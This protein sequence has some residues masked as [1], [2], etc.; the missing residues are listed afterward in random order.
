ML[1]LLFL[2]YLVQHQCSS[3]QSDNTDHHPLALFKKH[4]TGLLKVFTLMKL[5]SELKHSATDIKVIRT[6]QS[7]SNPARESPTRHTGS[8]TLQRKPEQKKTTALLYI[9]HQGKKKH[10]NLSWQTCKRLKQRETS[11]KINHCATNLLHFSP[12]RFPHS[13]RPLPSCV[14]TQ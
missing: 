11:P 1:N 9:S 5:I 12:T 8:N 4:T 3:W 2:S 14:R 13:C 7:T 6:S 10:S